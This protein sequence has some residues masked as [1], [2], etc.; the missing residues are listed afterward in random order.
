MSWTAFRISGLNS[1]SYAR[2]DRWRTRVLQITFSQTQC[3]KS[4]VL[5][6]LGM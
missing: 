6:V 1:S 2:Y 3:H 5:N 4:S